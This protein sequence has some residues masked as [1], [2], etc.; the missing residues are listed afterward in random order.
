MT[1]ILITTIVVFHSCTDTAKEKTS[2]LYVHPAPVELTAQL[3]SIQQKDSQS[4]LFIKL[5][6]VNKTVVPLSYYSMTCSWTTGITCDNKD[7]T[8]NPNICFSNWWIKENIAPAQSHN[9]FLTAITKNNLPK[10]KFRIG[11]NMVTDVVNDVDSIEHALSAMKHVVWS[12]VI[13]PEH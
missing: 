8:P 11:F 13:H 6:L 3:D 9:Y 7:I 5:S 4:V 1:V 2:S 10:K 12:N